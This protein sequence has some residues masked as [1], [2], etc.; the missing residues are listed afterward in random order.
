MHGKNVYFK[1]NLKK[2]V[3]LG[4]QKLTFQ[5]ILRKNRNT[6]LHF[7]IDPSQNLTLYTIQMMFEN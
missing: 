4:F 3:L 2:N 1:T 6:L 7:D 5:V